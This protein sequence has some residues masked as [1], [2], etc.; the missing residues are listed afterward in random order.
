[1]MQV[2][3]LAEHLYCDLCHIIRREGLLQV[4]QMVKIILALI[5]KLIDDIDVVLRLENIQIRLNTLIVEGLQLSD[6]LC[7]TPDLALLDSKCLKVDSRFVR[8]LLLLQK[9]RG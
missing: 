5:Q 6:L 1:M 3:E 2:A 4:A 8:V 9:G 7:Q